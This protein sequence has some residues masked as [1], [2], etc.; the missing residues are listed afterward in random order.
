MIHYCSGFEPEWIAFNGRIDP[1]SV[2]IPIGSTPNSIN[3]DQLTTGIVVSGR[4]PFTAYPTFLTELENDDDQPLIPSEGELRFNAK[5]KQYIVSSEEKFNDPSSVGTIHRL[6][7]DGCKY[8]GSGELALPLNYGLMLEQ[9]I[10]DAWLDEKGGMRIRGNLTLDFLFDDELL[11]R[12][13]SQLPMWPN[14]SP[15]DV[16]NAGFDHFIRESMDAKEATE[17]LDDLSLTGRFKRIPKAL[18]HTMVLSGVEF[19]YDPRE[20]SFVSEGKI[21]ISMLGNEQVYLEVAGKIELK[22]YRAGDELRLYLHGGEENWYYLE[23]RLG[24]MVVSTTDK[25]FEETLV[26][27][28]G[29]SRTIKEAGMRFG[30][31]SLGQHKRKNDFVG[32]FTEFD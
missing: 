11:E 12:I 22:R 32:R 1:K 3:R 21:G 28:K 27:L 6:T 26:N 10:G 24:T 5:D 13:A 29:K 9:F 2:A 17:A 25:V 30:F 19:L 7:K 14:S 20:A 18:R 23:Y 4:S 8:S 15:L 31:Q 16:L